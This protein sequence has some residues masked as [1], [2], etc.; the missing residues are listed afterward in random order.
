MDRIAILERDEY[1]YRPPQ[2][3]EYEFEKKHERW[4]VPKSPLVIS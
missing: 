3:T 4:G 1:E 2:R